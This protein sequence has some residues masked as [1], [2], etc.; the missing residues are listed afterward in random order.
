MNRQKN[1]ELN[2]SL[3]FFLTKRI[4]RHCRNIVI[5]R[6]QNLIGC[7]KVMIPCCCIVLVYVH[8]IAH[9]HRPD[10]LEFITPTAELVR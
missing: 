5:P 1:K 3:M 10:T 8:V 9:E 2:L 4:I 7:P 6:I